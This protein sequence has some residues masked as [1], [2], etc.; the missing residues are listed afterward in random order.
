M[1]LQHAV[2]SLYV[3]NSSLRPWMD[4]IEVTPHSMFLCFLERTGMDATILIDL[5]ISNETDFLLFFVSYLK[6]IRSDWPAFVS[7]CASVL[8]QEGLSTVASDVFQPLLPVLSSTGFP[9]NASALVRRI[10]T[11]LSMIP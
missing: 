11:I 8:G 5:L 3:N 10:Q 2:L 7:S 4:E 9:Y 6:H 1:E